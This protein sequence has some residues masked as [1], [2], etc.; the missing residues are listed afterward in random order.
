MKFDL[1]DSSESAAV[2]S[3]GASLNELFFI[4]LNLIASHVMSQGR[5][6]RPLPSKKNDSDTKSLKIELKGHALVHQ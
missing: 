5:E 4:R 3:A 2:S 1:R 6:Q